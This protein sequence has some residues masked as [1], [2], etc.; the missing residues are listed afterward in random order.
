M[1]V[2]LPTDIPPARLLC[3]TATL[4]VLRLFAMGQTLQLLNR[5]ILVG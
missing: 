1:E 4:N 5:V 2:F 3:P